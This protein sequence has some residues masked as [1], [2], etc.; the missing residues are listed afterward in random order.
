MSDGPRKKRNEAKRNRP[1]SPDRPSREMFAAIERLEA[2]F[3][4]D[5]ADRC[6]ALLNCRAK[7][8]LSF[9]IRRQHPAVARMTA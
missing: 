1:H 5:L 2:D 6:C 7:L 9:G 3:I 8:R 4:R